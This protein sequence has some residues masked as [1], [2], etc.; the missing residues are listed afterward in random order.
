MRTFRDAKLMAKALR[1]GLGERDIML[2]HSDCLELVARQFGVRD[3]NT[4]AAAI[5][6][7]PDR[8]PLVLPEGWIVSGSRSDAYDMGVDDTEGA[9][10]IRCKYEADD[11]AVADKV[12]GFGTL[13][14]SIAANAYRGRR[15]M[16]GAELKAGDVS[17]A[18]TLWMRV[19]GAQQRSLR[20]DNM[21]T[22]SSDGVLSGTTDWT[23]RRIVLDVP[24]EADSIHFGFY[25][26]GAGKAWAR[27]F[28]LS[29]VGDDVALT[30][31]GKPQSMP[32]NLDFSQRQRRAQ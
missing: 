19:D 16:L 15:L 21:E 30:G 11:P 28:E 4:L 3:W 24:E 27:D 1:Q 26:R 23:A 18:A 22:R 6:R 10:L 29:E 31:A 8:S 32:V 25:L 7:K 13:M 2:S 12:N 17:G 14:Q 20:F 5:D 9:A